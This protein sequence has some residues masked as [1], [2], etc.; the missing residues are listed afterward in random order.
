[1]PALS[2][3]PKPVGHCVTAVGLSQD[4]SLVRI[5][6]SFGTKWGCHGDFN[7]PLSAVTNK[8]VD[9]VLGIVSVSLG[10]IR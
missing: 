8:Q 9:T 5:R 10:N 1:M 3:P 4:G 2:G 6:N 7:L